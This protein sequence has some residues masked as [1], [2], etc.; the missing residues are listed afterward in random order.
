MSA[1]ETVK[2]VVKKH[3][4]IRL[5]TVDSKGFPHV[6][7]V[8]YAE[9]D[10]ENI[11]YFITRKDSRKAQQI[12]Q[13]G[14]VSFAIDHDCPAWEDLQKLQYIKGS[15]TAALIEDPQEMQKAFGLIMKKFP[16]L[17]D[18]P[19]DPADMVGIKVTLKEVFVSDN[20]LG[21]GHTETVTY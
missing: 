13:N 18:L 14:K 10:R 21:F 8:D 7:S 15:G 2:K 12:R 16:Y 20:T 1:V 5:A 6:R 3:N 9:G 17:K 11:L 4:L 19:G